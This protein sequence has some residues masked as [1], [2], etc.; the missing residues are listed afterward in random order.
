M[1][2]HVKEGSGS[3]ITNNVPGTP[4]CHYI[5]LDTGDHYLFGTA[6]WQLQGGGGGISW[7]TAVID[8]SQTNP[9]PVDFTHTQL[10]VSSFPIS[11]PLILNLDALDPAV[12]TPPVGQLEILIAEN[13][14]VQLGDATNLGG[15]KVGVENG[16]TISGDQI[17]PPSGGSMRLKIISTGAPSS[18]RLF[19]IATGIT[20]STQ[21]NV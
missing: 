6:S 17:T 3:P 12:G 15:L 8:A 2:V 16:C 13:Y 9:V 1:S 10:F 5:D 21:A 4:G 18:P 11:N 19:I 7:S 14:A 20:A